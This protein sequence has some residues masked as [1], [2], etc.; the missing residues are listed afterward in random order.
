MDISLMQTEIRSFYEKNADEARVKK[1]GR[2]FVEG[3]D[4][5]GVDPI[6]IEKQRE[7][8]LQKYHM[9]LG[10]A[11][12]LDLGDRLI[13]SG[14]Y[15]EGFLAYWFVKS[16]E[17]EFTPQTF[18]RL[19]CWLDH[20]VCNWALTDT[21]S[22]DIFGPFFVRRIVPINTVAG[23]C[24]SDVKW[25][26][27]AVPVSLI[28]VLK[29]DISLAEML[30]LIAPLM[31]DKEKVVHQGLGWFLREAWKLHREEVEIFLLRYKDTC[32]RL[33]IQYA[34]EKMTP[35]EKARFKR[36]KV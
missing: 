15:E 20:G 36:V 34:T 10:L 35:E 28:P 30:N 9:I 21:C 7:E 27:R 18:D 33:I 22:M 12:F 19:S 8:W 31:G 16:F 5:F 32:A 29:T 11:G 25:K 24:S 3:Y 23:W 14:K 13:A 6:L 17:K 2:F 4:S 1:Y 26:R